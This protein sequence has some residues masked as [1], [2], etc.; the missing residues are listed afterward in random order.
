MRVQLYP[1]KHLTGEVPD[2]TEK[3]ED[4][5]PLS[6][7]EIA[8]LLEAAAH[9]ENTRHT[10]EIQDRLI[11]GIKGMTCPRRVDGPVAK[12]MFDLEWLFTSK[13]RLGATPDLLEKFDRIINGQ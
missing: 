11:Q 12:R 10:A 7:E 5:H 6:R 4:Y 13:R 8:E 1:C 9:T 3:V 2:W